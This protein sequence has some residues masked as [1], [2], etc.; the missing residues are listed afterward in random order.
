MYN[1]TVEMKRDIRDYLRERYENHKNEKGIDRETGEYKSR[2]Y[3]KKDR[4]D[5]EVTIK[6]ETG[7]KNVSTQ[8]YQLQKSIERRG[9]K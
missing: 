7:Y 8:D 5:N 1:Y 6:T 9:R 4:K 3:A 2:Y